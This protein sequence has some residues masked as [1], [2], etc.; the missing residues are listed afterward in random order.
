MG[1]KPGHIGVAENLSVTGPNRLRRDVLIEVKDV[2]GVVG[3]LYL[4]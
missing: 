2:V 1:M 3:A 4:P